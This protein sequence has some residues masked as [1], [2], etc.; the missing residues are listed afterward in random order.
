MK[1]TISYFLPYLKNYKKEIFFALIGMVVMAGASTGSAHLM[2]PTMDRMFIDK[3][4]ELMLLIPL[5]IVVLFTLKAIGNF[6]QSYYMVY[7]GEDIVRQLRDRMVMH[8]MRQDMEFLQD[9]RNG[10]LISRVTRAHLAP[11]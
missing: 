2:K 7:V 1:K 9:M 8:L 6:V 10:E 4:R 3:D 5:A 11:C